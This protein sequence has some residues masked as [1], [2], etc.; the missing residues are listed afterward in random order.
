MLY[1][2]S[3]FQCILVLQNISYY[4]S[5]V[6]LSSLF[7][8][9][10]NWGPDRWHNLFEVTQ[11][12]TGW[13]GIWTQV[14]LALQSA[15]SAVQHCLLQADP[16]PSQAS[17]LFSI[18]P[19]CTSPNVIIASWL[20]LQ[21]QQPIMVKGV[22]PLCQH[23]H[24]ATFSFSLAVPIFLCVLPSRPAFGSSWWKCW[25]SIEATL[26]LWPPVRLRLTW[27]VLTYSPALRLPSSWVRP[28]VQHVP[29]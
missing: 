14:S 24:Q 25:P 10:H 4:I 15:L 26:F 8:R 7:Y 5:L 13:D 2:I 16:L 9:R 28:C 12:E 11:S 21:I 6:S 23:C 17:F 29:P 27:L 19:L 22:L 1:N 18:Y 3:W 20:Q